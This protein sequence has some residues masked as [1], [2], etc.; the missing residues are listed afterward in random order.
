M[1]GLLRM[2]L[3]RSEPRPVEDLPSVVDPSKKRLVYVERPCIGCLRPF[4]KWGVSSI[5]PIEQFCSK[6]CV[7][8]FFHGYDVGLRAGSDM[9]MRRRR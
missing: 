5:K 7:E 1:T 8:S 2:I 9:R 6:R 3:R 4:K